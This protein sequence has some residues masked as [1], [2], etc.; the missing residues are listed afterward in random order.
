MNN[1]I[2]LVDKLMTNGYSGE[3]ACRLT[4]ELIAENE[5]DQ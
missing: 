4:G 1:I 3:S 2:D 5:I